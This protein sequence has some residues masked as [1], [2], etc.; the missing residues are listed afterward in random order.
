MTSLV[1]HLV[2]SG[3]ADIAGARASATIPIAETLLN[4]VIALA[5]PPGCPVRD[6]T[7]HPESDDRFTA[8][9]KLARPDFLP[10]LN[11]KLRIE[12]QP[13]FPASAVMGFRV[14]SLPG[15]MSVAGAALSFTRALPP[16]V[17]L[18]ADLLTV[19]LRPLLERQGHA[20]LL[21]YAER[22]HLS[23]R[24]GRLIIDVA[25]RVNADERG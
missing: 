11:L 21:Q 1:Q 8:R 13:D 15:L 12:Q 4:R 23:T 2:A 20:W 18:D 5:L 14:A 3:F 7:V 10:A 24:D 25:L 17:R 9:I 22:L 16:G 19:D 6:L